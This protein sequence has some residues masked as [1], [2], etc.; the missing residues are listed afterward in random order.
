MRALLSVR[1]GGPETLVLVSDAAIPQPGPGEV[2]IRVH[3]ASLNFPDLLR[4]EDKY[5][6]RPPRP[7]SPGS[8]VAGVVAAVGSGV[9]GLALGERVMA[10]TSWGGMAEYVAVP[11]AKV[12]L[13]PE[14]MPFDEASAL[15]VTYATTWHALKQRADLRA[16][17]TLLVLGAS[18]GVGL[19][20]VE[21]GRA[22]GARV[23]AA[24][25]SAEKLAVAKAAGADAGIVYPTG[26]FTPDQQK[27]LSADLKA[28]C[29][30]QGAAV[31]FDPVGGA[32]SEP[33]FRAI[34]WGGRYLVIGFATGI[35]SLPLNL[36][37]LKGASV[38]GVFWGE[39]VE[40]DPAGHQRAVAELAELYA[41]GQI[42]PRIHATYPLDRGAEAL[43]FLASRKAMGKLVVT[44]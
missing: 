17:E 8:E 15:L 24:A 42:R 30:P 38:V 11:E 35:A 32:Y 4:L 34:G 27:A 1:T 12:S 7:F 5:Q 36:P 29:G 22:M 37:L 41:E 44:L 3:A 43:A 39:S 10:V 6:E 40:R 31:I 26:Q 20:A 23:V 19:A 2:L 14:G 18:G 21:L 16:G 9:H 33:A 28:A 13:I 25:S